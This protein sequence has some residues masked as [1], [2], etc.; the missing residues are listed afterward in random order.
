MKK[1]HFRGR[2]R[3]VIRQMEVNQSRTKNRSKISVSLTKDIVLFVVNLIDEET[4][5]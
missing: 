3:H 5:K 2:Q 4:A 1:Q